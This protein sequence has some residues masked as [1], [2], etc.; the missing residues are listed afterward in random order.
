MARRRNPAR[1]TRVHITPAKAYDLLEAYGHKKGGTGMWLPR[2]LSPAERQQWVSTFGKAWAEV[3]NAY[4]N[5]SSAEARNVRAHYFATVDEM[6][7]QGMSRSEASQ[8]AATT[9]TAQGYPVGVFAD[10]ARH[11]EKIASE[12]AAAL[13]TIPSSGGVAGG[14]H[15]TP[16][17]ALAAMKDYVAAGGKFGWSLNSPGFA[18]KY[19]PIYAKLINTFANNGRAAYNE[20]RVLV[21]PTLPEYRALVKQFGRDVVTEEFGLHE[22]NVAFDSEI[23]EVD[24]MVSI[25]ATALKQV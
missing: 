17:E 21:F 8:R 20:A 22:R 14:I 5:E 11:V 23:A 12:I 9:S 3:I 16:A 18:H 25:I 7:A 15:L 13:K 6:V 10:E 4:A 2:N 24:N 19:G 1:V